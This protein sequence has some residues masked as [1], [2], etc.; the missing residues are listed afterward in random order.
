MPYSRGVRGI[1]AA[2]VAQPQL[3]Y[4][5]AFRVGTKGVRV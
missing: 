3:D 5:G 4:G 1:R 2:M